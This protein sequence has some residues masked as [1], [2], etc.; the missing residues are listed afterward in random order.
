MLSFFRYLDI[1]N[2]GH[3][4]QDEFY[5]RYN[6]IDDDDDVYSFLIILT[7]ILISFRAMSKYTLH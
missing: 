3:V 5:S 7:M 6:I 1:N 4:T 2:D